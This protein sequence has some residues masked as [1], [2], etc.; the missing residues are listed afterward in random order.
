MTMSLTTRS[1]P[2]RLD[3]LERGLGVRHPPHQIAELFE[4][5]RAG[6]RDLGVVLDQQHR[7]GPR[8]R[9]A[10]LAWHRIDH[11]ACR[12]RQIDRDGGA[13]AERAGDLH[14][15]AG[16]MREAVHLRQSKAGALADRLRGEERV[17]H[18]GDDVRRDADAVVADG[19]G[20]ILAGGNRL[21]LAESD[22]LRRDRHRAAV[23]HGIAGIDHEVDQRDFE[24]ADV[25]RDR[26]D[27]AVGYRSSA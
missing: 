21:A 14:G 4:Q 12:A 8:R 7:A 25:D 23:G 26:P 19:D 11:G 27:I 6:A 5:V 2:F 15:A 10:R 20:D 17:E 1:M 16:L 18:I 24:F 3:L 9:V 13:V 22:V